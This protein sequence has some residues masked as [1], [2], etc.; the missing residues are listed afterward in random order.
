MGGSANYHLQA[1][2]A[3]MW[4]TQ[5]DLIMSNLV[6][7]WG[8]KSASLMSKNPMTLASDL[9]RAIKTGE[10]KIHRCMSAVDSESSSL[11]N[12]VMHK[13]PQYIGR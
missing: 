6:Q 3:R 8:G 12:D 9:D 13:S 2:S 5:I 4:L 10:V 1:S 11:G 7:N